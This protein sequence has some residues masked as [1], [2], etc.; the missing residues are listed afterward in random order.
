MCELRQDRVT[1]RR[2]QAFGVYHDRF[3][4]IGGRWWFA[5]RR[6]HSLARTSPSGDGPYDVFDFPET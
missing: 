4:R 1:G 3:R 2:S 6:Y 5:A